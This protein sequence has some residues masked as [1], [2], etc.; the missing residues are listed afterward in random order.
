MQLAWLYTAQDKTPGNH[1]RAFVLQ[2]EGKPLPLPEN[3]H[4]ELIDIFNEV[5]PGM[6]FGGMDRAPLSALELQAWSD[7]LGLHLSAWE[8]GTLLDM[9]QA[10]VHQTRISKAPAAP[11]PWTNAPTPEKRAAIVNS[12]RSLLRD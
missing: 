11:P 2:S 7:G 9:S 3:P 8:F 1:S 5:G 10:F 12:I 4:P 6:D